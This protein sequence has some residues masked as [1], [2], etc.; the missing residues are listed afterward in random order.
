LNPKNYKEFYN[1]VASEAEVHKDLVAEFV[2]FF[3]GK[4]RT[5]LSTLKSSRVNV[6]GLGTFKIRTNKLKKAIK[7]NKD[8]LGNLEKMTYTG[9]EKHVPVKNK[10]KEMETALVEIEEEIKKKKQFKDENK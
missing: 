10:L 9:Y 1:D 2:S 6:P 4:V 8:I 7:R 3:Y 5:S